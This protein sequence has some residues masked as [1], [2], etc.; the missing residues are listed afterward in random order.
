MLWL[1][2][3]IAADQIIHPVVNSIAG[4][5]YQGGENARK[6]RECEIFQDY[7]LYEEVYRLEEKS[8][9]RYY[10]LKQA[11]Y[12]W[13]DCVRGV[14][15]PPKEK[16]AYL[17]GRSF[18]LRLNIWSLV[19]YIL[20]YVRI[21]IFKSTP[22]WFLNFLQRGFV[23]TYGSFPSNKEIKDSVD[24]LRLSLLAYQKFGPYKKM[25]KEYRKKKDSYE[26]YQEYVKEVNYIRYYRLAVELSVIYLIAL[27]EVF[28]VLKQGRDF[29]NTHRKR[30]LRIVSDADLSSP[31]QQMI[32]EK[33][34]TVL[35]DESTMGA[36]V[37]IHSSPLLTKTKF[38][39]KNR[40]FK[41]GSDKDIVK[42]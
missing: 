38:L 30:F 13:I 32:F 3:H 29:T 9:P 23:E 34:H 16:Y 41:A 35:R 17:L 42:G 6:H 20:G 15:T 33:A 25:D 4:P 1:V 36:A 19:R 27:Y 39:T 2:T 40:I 12:N 31:L 10:F 8:S 11:F 24:Y 14:P 5:F 18:G 7:F 22:D 21:A 26:M 37:R 28:F